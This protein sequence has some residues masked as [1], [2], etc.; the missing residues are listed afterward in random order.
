M[1]LL[2]ASG[3]PYRT[4][5]CLQQFDPENPVHNLFNMWD[6]EAI[7]IG[8]S[9][10]FYYECLIQTQ[11][12]D[13]LYREDRGK[14]WCPEPI[15]LW[16]VYEPVEQQNFQSMYG[17]DSQDEMKF[18]LNYRA[19]LRELGHPPKVGSRIQTPHKNENWIIVQRKVG[20][21][22]M[23]GEIRLNLLCERFQENTTTGEGEI[24]QKK[25]NF[26]IN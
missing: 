6:E 18:E 14:L 9:P 24:E 23:W 13:P 17:I 26:T 1:T 12:I 20:E 4:L 10:I 25:P 22:K 11:T 19:V 5:G 3:T 2:N 21:F 16:A 8:G 15:Q 7:K